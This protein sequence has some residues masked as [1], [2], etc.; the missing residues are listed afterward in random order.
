MA[1]TKKRQ[2]P[3]SVKRRAQTIVND[4]EGY[5]AET[6]EAIRRSLETGAADLA[7]LVRR[8]ES[9]ERIIDVSAHGTAESR[10][11]LE[12]RAR[13]ITERASDFDFDTREAVARALEQ[14]ATDDELRRMCETAEAGGIVAAP[15]RETTEHE[16][17]EAAHATMRLAL[18]YGLPDWFL[19][20]MINAL[21]EAA[22]VFG[23]NIGDDDNGHSARGVADLFRVSGNYKWPTLADHISA[24]LKHPDTP[25]PIYD[26]IR[27]GLCPL[28]EVGEVNE[29]P[30]VIR[31]ALEVYKAEQEGGADG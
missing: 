8:A 1:T 11:Q 19:W 20:T 26:G 23:V 13:R 21:R 16:Y 9:G 30:D 3:A 17:H 2:R 14:G 25:E 7:E 27:K 12:A 15:L 4:A 10:E 5:D 18:S 24:V 28:T 29:H 31:V 6:R 22:E